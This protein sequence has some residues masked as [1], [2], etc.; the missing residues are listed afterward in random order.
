MSCRIRF[1]RDTES[2]WEANNPVLHDGEPGL[3]KT[4]STMKIGGGTR[5]WKHLPAMMFSQPIGL[6]PCKDL[7]IVFGESSVQICWTD[8]DD[9]QFQGRPLTTWKR[10]SL[11]RKA[12]SYPQSET[13]GEIIAQTSGNTKEWF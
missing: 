9:V 3:N 11:V 1:K 2:A 13:D 6:G 8:P 7:S 4:S 12:G 10:T 5:S